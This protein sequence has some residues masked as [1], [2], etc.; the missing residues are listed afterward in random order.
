[1]FDIQTGSLVFGGSGTVGP[2]FAFGNGITLSPGNSAGLLTT[3]N[4]FQGANCTTRIEINGTIAGSGYDQLKVN[5][6]VTLAGN[7]FITNTISPAP[8]TVFKIVDNDGADAISGSFVGFAEGATFTN[9]GTA[10][11]LSYV[12]GDGNDVM[13]TVPSAAG[14][15]TITNMA[16]VTNA[17]HITGLGVASLPYVLEASTNLVN[18]SAIQ[19]NNSDGSGVYFFVDPNFGLFPERFYRVQSP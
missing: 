4:H 5:G 18:W 16:V 9:N 19:T 11:K 2:V 8:G 6:T 17:F 3:S 13:L 7:L 12:G 15:S 1:L 10:F 14:P